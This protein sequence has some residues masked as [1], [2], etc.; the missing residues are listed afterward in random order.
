VVERTFAW[1]NQFR[2][3]RVRYDKRADIREAFLSLGC[4]LICWA[5]SCP[6]RY[7]VGI[8][9]GGPSFLAQG[10]P[11]EC[12]HSLPRSR[13]D[14]RSSAPQRLP[15]SAYPLACYWPAYLRLC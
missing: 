12:G 13:A 9:S 4:A 5:Y 2:H 11:A 7:P 10:L 8:R 14:R 1:L 3:L 6:R 15:L